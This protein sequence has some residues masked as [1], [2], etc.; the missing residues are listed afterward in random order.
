MVLN[1]TLPSLLNCKIPSISKITLEGE[2]PDDQVMPVREWNQKH[3]ESLLRSSASDGIVDIPQASPHKRSPT[4]GAMKPSAPRI[5]TSVEDHEFIPSA[6]GTPTR[7][8]DPYFDAPPIPIR[9]RAFASPAL[10]YRIEKLSMNIVT[11]T[12]SP[13]KQP[14]SPTLG[15]A[16]TNTIKSRMVQLTARRDAANDVACVEPIQIPKYSPGGFQSKLQSFQQLAAGLPANSL[17]IRVQHKRQ[18]SAHRLCSRGHVQNK[19]NQWQQNAYRRKAPMSPPMNVSSSHESM[20]TWT[21]DSITSP[22]NSP[23]DIQM[24]KSFSKKFSNTSLSTY[25]TENLGS[26]MLSLSPEWNLKYY[27]PRNSKLKTW[28]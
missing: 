19:V 10:R 22:P 23:M 14:D 18:R 16:N 15:N 26:L 12:A 7:L 17:I 6:F 1:P 13:T 21:T 4:R 5:S 20:H 27:L 11:S 24:E 25:T 2:E 8:I 9:A 3:E 28:M